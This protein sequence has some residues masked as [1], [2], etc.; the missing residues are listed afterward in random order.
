MNALHCD[1]TEITEWYDGLVQG[2]IH[3]SKSV[4]YATLLA[5]NVDAR[6]RLYLVVPLDPYDELSI[7][8]A[9]RDP[10]KWP[11]ARN[12]IIARIRQQQCYFSREVPER[13]SDV[14]LF[15]APNLS[16]TDVRIERF[17]IDQ[18]VSEAAIDEWLK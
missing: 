2:F 8:A 17:I 13:G 7:S 15:L 16:N 10:E 12:V 4:F 3:D 18:A 1:G 5:W 9:Y 11:E 6:K 14:P